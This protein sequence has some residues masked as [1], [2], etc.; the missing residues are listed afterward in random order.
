MEFSIPTFPSQIWLVAR[1]DSKAKPIRPSANVDE[2]I[3]RSKALMT[4]R[5]VFALKKTCL[6]PDL[7]NLS[8]TGAQVVCFAGKLNELAPAVIK[9]EA[10]MT[11]LDVPDALV[12]LQKWP[13]KIKVIGPV[14]RRQEM[15]VAFPKTSPQLREAFNRFFRQ[16]RKDGSY[17]RIVKKYYPTAFASFPDFFKEH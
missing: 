11:I 10:E 1:A 9:G 14:S 12:A 5:K 16:S 13:G 15:G 7:Y 17:D 3:A 6:D 8:A 2:D 4:N